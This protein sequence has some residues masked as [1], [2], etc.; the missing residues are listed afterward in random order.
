MAGT[1]VDSSQ[2][3]HMSNG[4]WMNTTL[5]VRVWGVGDSEDD[6]KRHIVLYVQYG[7]GVS[8]QE[9]IV[10]DN[11][12]NSLA[13]NQASNRLHEVT[14][15]LALIQA[16]CIIALEGI[17]RATAKQVTD[18]AKDIYNVELIPSFTGQLFSSLGIPSVTSHGKSRFVLDYESLEKV[19][20]S[21]VTRCEEASVK[22]EAAIE[23]FQDLPRRVE[24]LQKTWKDTQAMRARERE[25]IRL[26]NEDRQK[27]S[28]LYYLESEA[29]KL[30]VK[31]AQVNEIQNECRRLTVKI[32]KLPS[33]QEKRK[34]LKAKI[35]E[36]EEKENNLASKM[37]KVVDKEKRI[38][39]RETELSQRIIKLQKRTGWVELAT[40]EGAI[41]SSKKELDILQKQLGEKRSL[42]DKLL[43]RREGGAS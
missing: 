40:I 8:M 14:L 17:T 37:E 4:Y 25:L 33:L 21:I 11:F 3:K 12:M 36:Y 15:E 2:T 27:P 30:R 5:R 39:A 35:A 32:K 9:R 10:D 22:L 34:E 16:A 6:D 28:N 19:R 24:V 43:R 29:D 18:K 1:S 13:G 42:L 20:D 41:E 23:K 38:S 26:I 31:A 7:T